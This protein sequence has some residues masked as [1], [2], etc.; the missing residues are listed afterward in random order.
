MI[1]YGFAVYLLSLRWGSCTV[2]VRRTPREAV[3]SLGLLIS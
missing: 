2:R 3:Q 1:M